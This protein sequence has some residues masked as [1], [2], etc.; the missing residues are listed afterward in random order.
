MPR[1][2]N[3]QIRKN[4]QISEKTQRLCAKVIFWSFLSQLIFTIAKRLFIKIPDGTIIAAFL[5][6]PYPAL[7]IVKL[8]STK[9]IRLNKAIIVAYIITIALYTTN[10][11]FGLPMEKFIFYMPQTLY[12]ITL[13]Y[14]TYSIKN[15]DILFEEF[16]KKSYLIALI[17]ILI[18]FV[19]RNVSAYNMHFSYILSIALYFHTVNL[20]KKKR[21]KY[22]LLVLLEIGLII[23][24]GSRG[25]VLCYGVFL[26][27]YILL[28][29]RRIIPKILFTASITAISIN[30]ERILKTV[31]LFI[32]KTSVNSRTLN[33]LLQDASHD[34]GRSMIAEKCWP[35][36]KENAGT[37]LGIAGQFKYMEEYPHNIFLDLLLHWGIVI[38]GILSIYILFVIVRAFIQSKANERTLL[39]IFVC[40]GFVVLFFSG[41]Y[42]TFD[43]FFILL[44]IAYNIKSKNTEIKHE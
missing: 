43:G 12:G 40:Y 17:S 31:E 6:F 26:I 24:Y 5:A 32:S 41:T 42:L 18:I 38:G 23:V 30:I 21:L 28:G 20:V 19:D 36:I 44:G 25:P 34:S 3:S 1:N 27:L 33:L 2:S 11:C 37:G 7:L 15:L 14:I 8:L 35:L 10:Y 4:R 13:L 9:E 39:L 29:N 22:M 16:S